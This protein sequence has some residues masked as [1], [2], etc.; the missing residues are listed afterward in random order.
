MAPKAEDLF[1]GNSDIGKPPEF[2]PLDPSESYNPSD[3]EPDFEDF[4]ES[5]TTIYP[6]RPSG[7]PEPPEEPP[8]D[9]NLYVENPK[10]KKSTKK[11]AEE[12]AKR[13]QNTLPGVD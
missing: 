7:T 5:I 6:L 13:L 1:I 10:P 9:P 8:E 3:F 2:E 11:K 4:E 12:D